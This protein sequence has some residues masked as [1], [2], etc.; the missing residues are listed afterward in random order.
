VSGLSERRIA[1]DMVVRTDPSH[2]DAVGRWA[3]Q[4]S[5]LRPKDYESPALTTELLA[6][7]GPGE[8]GAVMCNGAPEGA[9][10]TLLREQG[11]NLRPAD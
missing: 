1:E 4:G 6:P 9:P 7:L 10:L 3:R 2:H 5:N 8:T 11:S